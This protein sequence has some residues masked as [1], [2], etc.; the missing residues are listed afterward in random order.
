MLIIITSQRHYEST[1]L[2]CKIFKVGSKE[3]HVIFKRTTKQK[4]SSRKFNL[5]IKKKK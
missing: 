1:Y 4:Y 2:K 3:N 5:R